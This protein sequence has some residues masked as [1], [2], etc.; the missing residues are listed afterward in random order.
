MRLSVCVIPG[1]R[2]AG[3]R[4]T[5]LPPHQATF[6]PTLAHWPTWS[7]ATG[8]PQKHLSPGVLQ[9]HQL[10]QVAT[11]QANQV[12]QAAPS[13]SVVGLDRAEARGHSQSPELSPACSRSV[14]GEGYMPCHLPGTWAGPY[15]TSPTCIH[16]TAMCRHA[17]P[18]CFP[19]SNRP[20]GRSCPA[21]W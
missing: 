12:S 2:A 6:L 3:P 13:R 20:G 5:A 8:A 1:S 18:R 10:D 21:A 19:L 11:G 9:R 15:P 7:T 16:S 4:S 17:V 14:T